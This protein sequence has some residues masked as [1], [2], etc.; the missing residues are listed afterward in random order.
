MHDEIFK[1]YE[2][3]LAAA[4]GP[5]GDTPQPIAGTDDYH[6]QAPT[7]VAGPAVGSSIRHLGRMDDE[8]LERIEKSMAA[9]AGPV[10]DTPQP[11]AGTDDYHHQ[12]PTPVA[13]PPVGYYYPAPMHR[14]SQTADRQAQQRALRAPEKL[15]NRLKRP[16][17]RLLDVRK[18]T[19]GLLAGRGGRLGGVL[20]RPNNVRSTTYAM[21]VAPI[22]RMTHAATL[23]PWHVVEI[24]L[25]VLAGE[26]RAM[27]PK[28]LPGKI[29]DAAI[30]FLAFSLLPFVLTA[31][32]QT[33]SSEN[34]LEAARNGDLPAARA[35]LASGADVDSTSPDGFTPLIITAAGNH[36][37]LA[38]AL[39]EAGAGINATTSKGF[40][41]LM[42]ASYEGHAG[43]TALL[44][45]TGAD[46]TQKNS[47]G[48]TALKLARAKN[49]TAVI[50]L[51]ERTTGGGVATSA[52]GGTAAP[53]ATS[54]AGA[55][56]LFRPDVG[57]TL[58]VDG[59]EVAKLA[60]REV[61]RTRLGAGGHFV[62][63]VS[64]EFQQRWEGIVQ[65][66]N[67]TQQPVPIP[68]RE[69][70]EAAR[71]GARE[72]AKRAAGMAK[73]YY[74]V[75][76]T[77][78]T[79]GG[80]KGIGSAKDYATAAEY[81]RKACDVGHAQSCGNLG[82]MYGAGRGVA[83][84]EAKAV[85]LYRKGC[86]AGNGSSCGNLGVMYGAGRGVAK[87]DAKAV[88]LYRKGCEAGN[89]SSCGN[90]GVMYADGRGVAKNDAKA[91]E[92]YRK[93]CE[94]GNTSFCEY[95]GKMY[96]SGGGVAK[97]EAKA[98]ELY[99]KACES[100]ED[101]S[102]DKLIEIAK[103]KQPRGAGESSTA[104]IHGKT[105]E[106]VWIP[107]GTFL[108]GCSPGDT[109]CK[110]DEKPRHRI[111]INKGFEMGKYEVTQ[112]QWKAVMGGNPSDR[113]DKGAKKPI[114][115]VRWESVQR[116]L[117]RLNERGDGYRYRLP[118]EAEW[119][120]AARAGDAGIRGALN[121]IAWYEG[122]SGYDLHVVGKKAAN[123]WGLHDMLGNIRE[124][125]QDSFR[126]DYASLSRARLA[127]KYE[128]EL[129]SKAVRGGHYV[130]EPKEVRYSYRG[131]GF[132]KGYDK[133]T[134]FRYVRE[135]LP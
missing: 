85:E 93:A 4:A 2:K 118:T 19:N 104:Q 90:L 64:D 14:S 8:T 36:I 108:M 57:C 98:V 47:T 56:V 48:L 105:V 122:N 128:S 34:L 84:V 124:W 29:R 116:H 134:G 61:F 20:W 35:A 78:Y 97:D 135:K 43:M 94:G 69:K 33:P 88:E 54:A 1:R 25:D 119:E 110:D 86:D 96:A 91:V 42:I 76:K 41:A 125:C 127:P 102:C 10:R 16:N 129:D 68:L 62:E 15:N 28:R 121:S 133:F 65:I 126:S 92:L 72:R 83:K 24:P 58:S 103:S 112:E 130:K 53:Q 31:S 73:R 39:I 87:D 6:H 114:H 52:T 100:G 3:S 45:G 82:E 77:Y 44:L 21:V 95:L 120:Y 30:L 106:F 55:V 17:G 117:A 26:V 23:V 63:A 109:E 79:L 123:A 18:Q 5:V 89:G 12:A 111:W 38:E 101:D 50:Q 9:V 22:E 40:T 115:N 67:D 49:H 46:A 70:V 75:A 80:D 99:R 131:F 51:L 11:V 113:Y 71:E 59:E 66:V 74:G 7:P 60:A 107:P 13:G 132:N 27:I 32:P 37:A 81:Y